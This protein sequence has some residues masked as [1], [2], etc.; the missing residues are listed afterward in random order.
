MRCYA[1]ERRAAPHLER[2][3]ERDARGLERAGGPLSPHRGARRL[4]LV[5][6]ALAAPQ[7]QQIAAVA[8]GD[9]PPCLARLLKRVAQP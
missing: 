4:P 6:I 8:T 1:R 5:Q 3:V 9:A 2:V 7:A